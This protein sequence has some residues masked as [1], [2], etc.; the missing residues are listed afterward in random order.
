MQDCTEC[1]RPFRTYIPG[2]DTLMP[3]GSSFFYSYP[4][5]V[6]PSCD[7]ANWGWQWNKDLFPEFADRE[8]SD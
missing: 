6:C 7:R 2:K 8:I 1:Q 4:Q 5:D 3:D